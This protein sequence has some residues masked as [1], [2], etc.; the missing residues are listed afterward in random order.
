LAALF[1][2]I[3]ML[4]AALI[5]ASLINLLLAGVATVSLDGVGGLQIAAPVVGVLILAFQAG[6]TF[7]HLGSHDARW[8]PL[9]RIALFAGEAAALLAGGALALSGLLYNLNPTAGDFEF[10]PMFFG[11]A[12][13][14][15][16][17]IGLL[18]LAIHERTPVT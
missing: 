15:H 1:E 10:A 4:R 8:A 7:L 2:R 5:I 6:F 16:A 3:S 11:G 12:L 18:Y 9:T 17:T 14:A 13:A